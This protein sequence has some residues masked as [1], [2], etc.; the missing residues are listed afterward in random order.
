MGGYMVYP[1][2][3]A[4]L[5]LPYRLV[6]TLTP[7]CGPQACPQASPPFL[8]ENRKLWLHFLPASGEGGESSRCPGGPPLRRCW[9]AL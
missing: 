8:V 7:P 9:P 4:G 1:S 6:L 2:L 5:V 3:R